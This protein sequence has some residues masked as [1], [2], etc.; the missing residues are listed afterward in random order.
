MTSEVAILVGGLPIRGRVRPN[1]GLDAAVLTQ[2]DTRP[3]FA[4]A[5]CIAI[6]SRADGAW[7]RFG[8][9]W[10]GLVLG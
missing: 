4:V 3:R 5:S 1:H 9:G 6:G 2:N 10:L 7:Q 8:G